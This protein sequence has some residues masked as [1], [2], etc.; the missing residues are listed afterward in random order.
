MFGWAAFRV[1]GLRAADWLPARS[2]AIANIA[3]ALAPVVSAGL[4]LLSIAA[5]MGQPLAALEWST[6]EAMA[7]GTGMGWAFS[8]RTAFLI[9]AVAALLAARASWRLPI[10]A[11][12]FGA[13]LMTLGWS[14][15][16]AAT[17]G[18]LGS[19]HRISNGVHLLAA[20]LWLGAI[21]WFLHL[22][23]NAHREPGHISAPPLLTIMHRFA[24]LGVALVTIVAASGLLNA[25]LIFGLEN[26]PVTLTT[27]YGLL[28]AVKIGAVAAMLAFGARNARL[29]RQM[30]SANV[31]ADP[32]ED[33]AS[34]EDIEPIE[35]AALPA[36]RRS[37]T[38]EL[39]LAL[40]VIG[41]VAVFG[42]L[43]PM[44]MT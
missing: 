33:A 14:G 15:H 24:P 30:V 4:M 11:A 40:V 26:S 9:A 34:A 19:L 31:A 16:A 13:A 3:A 42:M 21:G 28:L 5:M 41:L 8:V 17:E 37:L 7:L 10:A 27:T 43:S 38:M 36:L 22:S 6:I 20:G 18:A 29:S 44:M 23:I 25:Q 35:A 2:G 39:S 1:I 12:C 32:T